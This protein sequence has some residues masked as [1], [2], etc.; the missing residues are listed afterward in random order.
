MLL[1]LVAAE[2]AVVMIMQDR[3]VAVVVLVGKIIYQ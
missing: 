3:A 2:P 1:P